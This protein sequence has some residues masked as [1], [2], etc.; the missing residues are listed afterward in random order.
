MIKN[1]LPLLALT[2]TLVTPCYA[3]QNSQ[4]HDSIYELV[5][6]TLIKNIKADDYEINVLPLDNLL[7]LPECAQPLT[8]V[9]TSDVINPGRTTVGVRCDKGAK[10]S[11]FTSAMVKIFDQVF[12]L[13]QPIQLGEMLS[14]QHLTLEKR[15]VS[16][17][18]GDFVTRIE[19]LENKK[20]TR[21]LPKGSI[22]S[23]KYFV[24]PFLVKRGERVT[25][26]A[27]K[28]TFNIDMKGIAMTDGIKDQRISVK[29]ESSG[30]MINATVIEAGRV[31]V[32]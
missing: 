20:A 29:N 21:Y 23:L 26:S 10:W 4:S 11:I 15:D 7:R 32:Q 13:T 18:R 8:A 25:I 5:K 14:H 24:E 30:R 9:M 31:S 27:I 6:Q 16:N 1:T 28:S 19:Q 12:I 17:L 22:I 2:L 3:E